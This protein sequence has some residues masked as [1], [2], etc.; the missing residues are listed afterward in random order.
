M[1]VGLVVPLAYRLAHRRT[2]HLR[3][4][5]IEQGQSRRVGQGQLLQCQTAILDG[6]YVALT[7]T[8]AE[9]GRSLVVAC[10]DGRDTATQR[11][12]DTHGRGIAMANRLSFSHIEYRG[13]GNEVV[14]TVICGGRT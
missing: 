11:A 6:V 10:T 9:V 14:G 1:D 5:P 4:H 8:L 2:I 3:H 12:F 7:S 13:S